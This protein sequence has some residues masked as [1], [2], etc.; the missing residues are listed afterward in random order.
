[1]PCVALTAILPGYFC[2]FI[3]I[4]SFHPFPCSSVKMEDREKMTVYNGKQ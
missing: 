4:S 1:M 3:I 2:H